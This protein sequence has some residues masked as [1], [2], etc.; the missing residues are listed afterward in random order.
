MKLIFLHPDDC[1]LLTTV[2]SAVKKMSNPLSPEEA[3]RYHRQLILPEIG[4]EGQVKLRNAR[5]FLTGLGGLGSV[6]AYYLAA[7]G[8][9]H[10]RLVDKDRVELGNLNRQI[11]HFSDNI[12]ETKANSARNKLRRLNPHCR[13]EALHETITWDNGEE[14]AGNADLI[15]D[16]T[17]NVETRRILNRVSLKKGIPFVFGGVDGLTGMATT[18]VPGKTPCFECLFPDAMPSKAPPGILGPLPGIIAG[19]Q[20]LVAIKFL[21][22]LPHGL[23]ESQMLYIDGATMNFKMIHLGENSQCR[24]CGADGSQGGNVL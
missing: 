7:A 19:I 20:A 1:T 8:V 18:F 24:V 2:K 3:L 5:V 14:M 22:G 4:E 9:G 23:L 10:L 17:D 6:S 11:L 16:G 21:V 15:V 13:I 12:G